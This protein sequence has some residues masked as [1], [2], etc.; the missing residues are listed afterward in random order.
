MEKVNRRMN[1]NN[2][3][4][5]TLPNNETCEA[6]LDTAKTIYTEESER[7]KQVETKTS[8]TLAFVGVLFGAY[9]TYLGSFKL[10]THEISY[11]IYTY[12]FQLVI[13]VALTV[14]IIYFLMSIK[15]GEFEQ[16]DLETIV[17]TNFSS[18][19]EGIA[20]L[21]IAATYR[22]A[23]SANK[24]GIDSKMRFYSMGLNY[25]LW[26]LIIF[27]LYFTIEEVIKHVH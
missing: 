27:A 13:F 20:K 24:N 2:A 4:S 21:Q 6:I 19:P 10:S 3:N 23:I 26:A 18:E 14:S 12:L 7:F 5:N 17:D 15:T 22:D 11:L 8:I 25:L 9:L 1:M 16:V